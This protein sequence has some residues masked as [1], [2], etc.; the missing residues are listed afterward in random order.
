MFV[1][2]FMFLVSKLIF[3]DSW[4]VF[5]VFHGFSWFRVFHSFRWVFM[6]FHSIAQIDGV[7]EVSLTLIV[8]ET[9]NQ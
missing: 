2:V 6:V 8:E 7:P 3:H 4:W 5:M 1:N 9:D